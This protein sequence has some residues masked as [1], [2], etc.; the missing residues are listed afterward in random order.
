MAQQFRLILRQMIGTLIITLVMA[1]VAACGQLGAQG[2]QQSST[3][4]L[5]ASA[6]ATAQPCNEKSTLGCSVAKTPVSYCIPKTFQV[7]DREI[8]IDSCKPFDIQQ[9][10]EFTFRQAWIC[11]S[12]SFSQ[13][14]YFNQQKYLDDMQASLRENYGNSYISQ[15]WPRVTVSGHMES[16][17]QG[18]LDA[19]TF[20]SIDPNVSISQC[21]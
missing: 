2:Q 7:S 11:E 13:L 6:T 14:S 18:T 12:S 17:A 4:A 1:S 5:E 3:Q 9:N 16:L 8:V 21:Q 19:I 20:Y 15:G 10:G